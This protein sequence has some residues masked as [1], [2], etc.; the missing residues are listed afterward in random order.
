MRIDG[1]W[2][3]CQD[4]VTR[5][6]VRAHIDDADGL[7]ISDR[8]LVDTGADRTVL[9]ADF[10]RRIGVLGDHPPAGIGLVGVGGGT[11]FVVLPTAL[12]LL[13]DDGRVATIRG[14]FA[15]F[16]DPNATDLSILGRDVLDHFR[17][18]VSRLDGEVF[19]LASSHHY[20]VVRT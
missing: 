16:T 12:Q 14:D 1:E 11:R 10:Q 19:L 9:S 20:Q 13:T 17:V 2:F 15:A 7:P 18:I 4:G 5:P 3:E 6:V 8:F